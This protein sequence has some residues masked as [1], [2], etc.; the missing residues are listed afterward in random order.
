[1]SGYIA[2]GKSLEWTLYC[3]SDQSNYLTPSKGTPIE[4]V[5]VTSVQNDGSR[6]NCMM[7][8][9]RFG[10]VVEEIHTSGD[11]LISVKTVTEYIPALE[12]DKIHQ[13]KVT[14][15]V[16]ATNG[17]SLKFSQSIPK[18]RYYRYMPV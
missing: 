18:V 12:A 9:A 7:I 6:L 1:M 8:H 16:L 15:T 3:K 5:F 14:I 2:V 11:G 17:A 10:E 4:D 13:V